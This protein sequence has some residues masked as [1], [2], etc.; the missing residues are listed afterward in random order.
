[1]SHDK[2]RNSATSPLN[3]LT[4]IDAHLHLADPG[5]AGKVAEVVED[6]GQH[7]VSQMLSNATDYQSSLE[8]IRLAKLFPGRVLAAVGVHPF[9]VT[10]S[11]DLDLDKF[12]KTIDD[13]A[14]WIT[15]L[16]EIGLDG[17]YTQ[18]EGIKAT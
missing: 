17:K 8:T 3:T 5:Y 14:S 1:M 4:Y 11:N 7:N 9:T 12:G 2:K 15:A 6:A 16:G 10:K 18:D 13:S